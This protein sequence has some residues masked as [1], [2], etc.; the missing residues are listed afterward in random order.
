MAEALHRRACAVEPVSSIILYRLVIWHLLVLNRV[1]EAIATV[2]S[3]VD[4]IVGRLPT[5]DDCKFF[6]GSSKND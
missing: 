3:T 6:C 2:Q 1:D 5:Q 4:G